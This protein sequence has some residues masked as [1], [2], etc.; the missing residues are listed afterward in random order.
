MIRVADYIAAFLCKLG[1][2]DIFMV[3]GGGMMFLSDALAKCPRLNIV[4]N[5]HEQASAMA[6]ETYA[7]CNL[8]IGVAFVT[9]GCGST[10]AITGLLGAWQDNVPLLVISGQSKRKETIRNSGLKLRQFGVQETDIIT[11]VKSITKYAEM[12]NEPREIAYHLEK[13]DAYAKSGR[14]GPV[15]LDIPLDVQASLIDEAK[16]KHYPQKKTIALNCEAPTRKTMDKLKGLLGNSR[17]PIIIAGQ[18]IRLGGAIDEFKKFICEKRI[19]VVASRL[20]IN[21]LPTNHPLFFGLIGNKGHR[22]GNFAVQNA[23]LIIALGSRLSVSSIGHEYHAFARE[24]KITVVDIDREEH[25]KKTLKIDLFIHADAKNFLR[26][27]VSLTAKNMDRDW[28]DTCQRW[29]RKYLICSPANGSPEGKIDLYDF[30]K[31]LSRHLKHDSVVVTDSGS[32]SYVVPQAINLKEGQLYVTSSA[33]GEMGYALPAVIGASFARNRKEII[34]IV[35]DGSFQMNIQELQTIVHNRLPVKIFVWNNDGYLSI[36]ATQRKFFNGRLIGTDST[37]G[38]S[39]PSL[40]KISGAYGIKFMR[41]GK[42]SFLDN[43]IEKVLSLKEP[44]ICEVMCVRDQEIVPT[45]SS[46]R[47]DDGT[48]VSKPLEDMYPFLDRKEFLSEMIVKPLD[49]S[50]PTEK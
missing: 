28:I 1:V 34:G 41:V 42:T 13:A 46:V 22:S 4:C 17:R 6:A 25:R 38:V 12:V 16:L 8:S 7:K 26:S 10:N 29:K 33:Q 5:H 47:K 31:H 24:A 9:S 40:E 20:G 11:I 43:V 21:N 23:D 45:V 15:W 14:P 27:A 18:G 2:K 50:M 32:T 36:R 3:S 35:G 19:P 30:V 49:G 48:M 44:V 37:S 39:F